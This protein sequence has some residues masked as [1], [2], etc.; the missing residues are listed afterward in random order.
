M[1]NFIENDLEK[2]FSDESDSESD[3]GFSDDE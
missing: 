1:E 2:S 3:S